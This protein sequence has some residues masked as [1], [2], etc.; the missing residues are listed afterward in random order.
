M[1]GCIFIIEDDAGIA[2]SLRYNLAREGHSA[3]VNANAA[4]DAE[5]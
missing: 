4:S 5:S 1:P 2:E 3:R